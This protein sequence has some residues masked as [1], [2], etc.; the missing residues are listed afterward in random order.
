MHD[1]LDRSF[2]RIFMRYRAGD[3]SR[4]HFG[5]LDKRLVEPHL[6]IGGVKLLL[7]RGEGDRDR[8]GPSRRRGGVIDR[9]ARRF[10]RDGR[11]ETGDPVCSRRK[12]HH[13]AQC[14]ACQ[15]SDPCVFHVFLLSNFKS[16]TVSVPD[17]KRLHP[18]YR[19]IYLIPYVKRKV[20]CF[21]LI[22]PCRSTGKHPPPPPRFSQRGRG[23]LRC[24]RVP[25]AIPAVYG[26]GAA[27]FLPFRGKIPRF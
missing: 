20:N 13:R 2:A 22:F 10:L 14:K 11:K 26:A 18:F 3:Q 12:D 25:P 4:R 6:Q 21:L 19:I 27:L 17:K 5:R 7:H 16:D 9:E 8:E 23:R 24:A 1:R 15:L